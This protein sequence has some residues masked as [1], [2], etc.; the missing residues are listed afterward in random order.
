MSTEALQIS[1]GRGR[2]R[3]FHFRN[4]DADRGVIQQIFQRDDYALGRLARGG[5]LQA[6]YD[7]AV[8]RGDRP[9]ILD[10]GANIGASAVWFSFTFPQARI[11]AIEPDAGNFELLVRNTAGLNVDARKAAL[12]SCAGTASLVDPGQGEWGYRTV[13][14]KDGTIEQLAAESLVG[15]LA[16]DGYAPFIAKIDIEGGEGE[17]FSQRVEWIDLFP[18]VI[19]ELH[20]WLLPRGGTARPFLK[21]MAERDRDFVYLGENVFS[22]RN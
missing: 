4:S 11:V 18:L 10:A 17:L 6:W 9:L 8:R 20:D 7:D 19:V 16:R 1:D 21:C 12:A 22:I 13:S 14:S 15:E 2:T 3:G 5:E